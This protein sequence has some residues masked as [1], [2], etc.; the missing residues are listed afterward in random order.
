MRKLLLVVITLTVLYGSSGAI[1]L[2]TRKGNKP[3]IIEGT[4]LDMSPTFGQGKPS[5]IFPH[6]RLVKYRVDRVCKGKYE[7]DEIVIDHIIVSG[8]ELKDRKVGDKV[9]A[10]TWRIKKEG[11][12]YTYKGIRD[13]TEGIKYLYHGG[14]VLM[15]TS[16][17]C[18]FDERKL[19]SIQ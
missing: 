2:P 4:I 7:E 3:I 6:Y 18:S 5:G 1:G 12:I 11:T 14:D 19:M 15:A 8:D 9:Y 10:L 17:G 13:S 16:T